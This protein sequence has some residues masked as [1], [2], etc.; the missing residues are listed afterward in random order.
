MSNLDYW[1]TERRSLLANSASLTKSK[2]IK[3]Q[4][5]RIKENTPH[6]CFLLLMYIFWHKNTVN[7]TVTTYTEFSTLIALPHP[8][9]SLVKLKERS[10]LIDL[11]ENKSYRHVKIHNVQKRAV[12][13]YFIY[14]NWL[15]KNFSLI[16]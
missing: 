2:W 3:M 6:W 4:Y 8:K 5:N 14:K 15:N 9:L 7:D 1:W 11:I 16:D 10:Y 13:E 12:T